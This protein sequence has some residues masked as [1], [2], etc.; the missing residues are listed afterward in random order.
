MEGEVVS[1]ELS[2]WKSSTCRS[3]WSQV[4]GYTVIFGSLRFHSREL[5]RIGKS[6][7]LNILDILGRAVLNLV[8]HIPNKHL[9]AG[10]TAE[11]FLKKGEIRQVKL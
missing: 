4:A 9:R 7:R 2:A 11:E 10:S 8:L 1:G 3:G 5:S 6:L